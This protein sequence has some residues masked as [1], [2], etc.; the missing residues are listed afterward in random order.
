MTGERLR[1]FL[2]RTN[3]LSVWA[4]LFTATVAVV[5]TG[6]ILWLLEPLM[7]PHPYFMFTMVIALCALVLNKMSGLYALAL[8]LAVIVFLFTTPSFGVYLA[9]GEGVSLFAFG[10]SALFLV[11]VAE[12]FRDLVNALDEADHRKVML[13]REMQHR[14]M[15]NLQVLSSTINLEAADAKHEEAKARLA[16]VGRRVAGMARTARALH[17]SNRADHYDACEFLQD[18]VHEIA[19][20]LAADR[21][22]VFS[23]HVG[24]DQID[25]ESAELFGLVVNELI[26]NAVK[27][28]FPDGRSGAVVV[29]FARSPE[30]AL[31]LTVS[32][33][34]VGCKSVGVRGSGLGLVSA[35]ARVR[36]G[37][38]EFQ[39]AQ[40]G[41]RVV[42]SLPS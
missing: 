6:L 8:S 24:L 21:R 22:I 32:D 3:K 34:G 16:R 4:R 29:E 5:S 2:Q 28:A 25:R 11:V 20:S 27:H 19:A 17:H 33:N 7:A 14:V 39:D 12:L 36:G 13:M 15:N 31:R 30:R 41:C 40:P 18:L 42:V 38:V 1:Q 37:S 9:E 23:C 26:T 35:L 10:I